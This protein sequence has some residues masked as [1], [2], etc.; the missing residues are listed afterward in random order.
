[1]RKK[2]AEISEANT[3]LSVVCENVL[4][5]LQMGKKI[6]FEINML[7]FCAWMFPLPEF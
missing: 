7:S 1:M 3:F 2:Y 5:F 6:V 4:S